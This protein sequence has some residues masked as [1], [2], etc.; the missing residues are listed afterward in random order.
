MQQELQLYHIGDRH[1]R[2]VVLLTLGTYFL[3]R[4]YI[5][6]KRKLR[7]IFHH[8]NRSTIDSDLRKSSA[9]NIPLLFCPLLLS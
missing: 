4:R 9:L 5:L 2:V 7:I 3:M 1:Q 8:Y 6:K